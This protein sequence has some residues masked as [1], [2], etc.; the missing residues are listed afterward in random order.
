LE[1]SLT[2]DLH[3]S[4]NS[5]YVE[6]AREYYNLIKNTINVFDVLEDVPH[7]REMTHE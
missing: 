4:N 1:E 3:S 7:F 2:Q 5:N 6:A